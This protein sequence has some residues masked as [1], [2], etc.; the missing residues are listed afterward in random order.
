MCASGHTPY[1]ESHL[2]E[3]TDFTQEHSST[4]HIKCGINSNCTFNSN[5]AHFG[6]AEDYKTLYPKTKDCT[7]FSRACGKFTEINHILRHKT[8]L[9]KF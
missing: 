4:F 6:L 7:F 5:I 2:S 9:N 1:N 3:Q 8:S